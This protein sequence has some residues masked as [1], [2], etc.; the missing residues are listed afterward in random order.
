MGI[1]NFSGIVFQKQEGPRC[2]DFSGFRL[3]S[4][5]A[6]PEK[7]QQERSQGR[8]NNSYNVI[9]FFIFCKNDYDEPEN[10]E[11]LVRSIFS[12][13]ANFS[14][15]M[16][17]NGMLELC[18]QGEFAFGHLAGGRWWAFLLQRSPLI[19]NTTP[20]QNLDIPTFGSQNRPI[21]TPSRPIL[22]WMSPL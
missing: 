14:P 5:K 11:F 17:N 4:T 12:S 2:S 6:A 19:Q 21:K 10:T 3:L 8:R 1:W 22:G 13:S 7:N 16:T 9:E 18:H 15:L 20:T